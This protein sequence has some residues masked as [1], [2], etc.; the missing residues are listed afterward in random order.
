MIRRLI[1][2]FGA[3]AI[4]AMASALSRAEEPAAPPAMTA[5]SPA[6][7]PTT[8]PAAEPSPANSS[9]PLSEEATRPEQPASSMSLSSQ[10][11]EDAAAD[12][13]GGRT[14]ASNRRVRKGGGAPC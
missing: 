12:K 2:A 13:Q 4:A 7:E 9:A 1:F 3:M 11:T 6:E 5:V 14:G 8:S 10:D